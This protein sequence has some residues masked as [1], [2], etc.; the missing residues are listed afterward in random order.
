MR[1][2]PAASTGPS[3]PC[4]SAGRCAHGIAAGLEDEMIE[5]HAPCRALIGGQGAQR[6]ERVEERVVRTGGSRLGAGSTNNS[7]ER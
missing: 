2:S 3:T 1:S 5:H 6:E 4:T 7:S